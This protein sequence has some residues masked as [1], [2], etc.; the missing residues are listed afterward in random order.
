MTPLKSLW[1]LSPAIGLAAVMLG[2]SLA[3]AQQPHNVIVFVADGLRRESVTPETMP[4]FWK[5]RHAGVDFRNSH[6]V[7]PTF[8]TANASVIATGHGLGD[9]GDYSNTLY[10]GVWLTQ[11]EVDDA[12]GYLVPFLEND[13]VLANMN[14][15]FGGNYL[16]EQT[17][18][19][20]ARA[21]GYS[22]ASI[23]K[24]GPTAIQQ[25]D[26]VHWDRA[27]FLSTSG[28]IVIDDATGTVSG[29]PVPAELRKQMIAAGLPDEAPL[30]TNGHAESSQYNN[31]F[32]GD[33]AK[34]GTLEANVVQQS[35]FAN[36]A[37]RVLL[38]KFAEAGK[39]FL[40]LFWSRDPDG[41]QHDEGDSLQQ[42][43]PG[44]NGPTST[45]GLRNAD[46]ALKQLLDWLDAHPAI[47][48]KTDVLVTSDH[49]FATISRREVAPAGV[50]TSEVS[51]GLAYL[52]VLKEAPEPAGTL[53]TG[54]LAVD[55]AV[56]TGMNLFDPAVRASAGPSVYA[57]LTVGGDKAQHPAT[58]SALL[59][60]QVHQIDGS[61]ARLIIASNGGSDMIYVPSGDPKL[62]ASTLAQL[63]QFDYVGGLFVDDKY[64]ADP[65]VCAGALPMSAIGLVGASKVPRPA[66]V[67]TYKVFYPKPGDLQSAA[68]ISDTTLQEG[69]G[70]HGGFGR[71]QT[72]NNMAAL[73]PDFKSGFIDE[74]P[75]GNIDIV[76][77]LARILGL[78]LPS[79]G[80][81]RGRIL[82]EA[83]PGAAAIKPEPVKQQVSTPAGSGMQT[84]L[85][86]QQTQGVTY[87]DSACFLAKDA[88][89]TC[90]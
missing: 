4:T 50:L 53:P 87:Y 20:A 10:P 76:P 28:A 85:N 54:F 64:C 46:R 2:H 79:V 38:P 80:S 81:L 82:T 88:P 86:Y 5:V 26:A 27:G 21:R 35:W 15:V 71:E 29:L 22:V 66:I 52:P 70:M 56:R 33:A 17:I 30:R 18:L 40:V 75:M 60:T 37:T 31:G 63:A 61:D 72:F 74:A 90:N 77:T 69:Q 51:S 3:R 16:G 13:P 24:L 1:N 23:G 14:G 43:S 67:V 8:T 62:V 59:G 19:S 73:G 44:I 47:K 58:G 84:V 25:V 45:L 9:T 6:A 89:H 78:Q 36:V 11:P 83:M 48:A 57:Q 12:S 34:P 65:P 49:G 39:P 68:Q 7:F 41:T 55:L 42:L 32:A